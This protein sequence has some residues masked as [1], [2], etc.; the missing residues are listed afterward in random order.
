[1]VAVAKAGSRRARGEKIDLATAKSLKHALETDFSAVTS[2]ISVL[3]AFCD[4][5][6][7]NEF[8]QSLREI[9]VRHLG[10]VMAT[11][12]T[13]LLRQLMR[14]K[15]LAGG[16]PP[17]R[18]HVGQKTP[19]RLSVG[20][21]LADD[22][23]FALEV[24]LQHADVQSV[25]YAKTLVEQRVGN[26]VPIGILSGISGQ[27]GVHPV[28]LNNGPLALG[29]S[30]AHVSGGP[31]TLGIFVNM[32]QTAGFLSCSHVLSNCGNA[33]AGD[34][35]HHPAPCD[36]LDHA[37]IGALRRFVDLRADGPFDMDVAFAELV[38]GTPTNGNRIPSGHDWPREG[39]YLGIPVEGNLPEPRP[40]VAKIGRSTGRTTGTVALE[41]VGPIDIYMQ[42]LGYN[43]AV[44]GLIEVHWDAVN[45]PFSGLG[46]SGSIVYLPDSLEPV[47]IIVAGGF[48]TIE[49]VKVGVSYV[50]PLSPILKSWDL[51]LS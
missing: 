24:R 28:A 7:E 45:K 15:P 12:D 49:K 40:V 41:N 51:S 42:E 37:G 5:R 38:A 13:G 6:P 39:K 22:E 8:A 14:G 2:P 30:V 11:H 18:A 33:V 19:P 36:S 21:R 29:A 50:S 10:A 9:P 31:G 3:E 16:L 35:I 43:V 32:G 25:L 23:A 17:I 48:A 4:V 44:D 20:Y 34:V 46:D 47:G 1:M 26:A 27:S